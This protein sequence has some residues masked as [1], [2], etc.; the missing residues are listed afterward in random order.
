MALAVSNLN[1]VVFPKVAVEARL[2]KDLTDYIVSLASLKSIPLPPAIAAKAKITIQI[3]SL[4]V[5]NIL[6]SVEPILGFELKDS[7][8]RT[9]GYT[10]VDQAIA[11]LLPRIE[12]AWQKHWK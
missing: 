9:G 4:E 12:N 11:H 8:V 6:C 5:V 1:L 7:T 2:R 3:D 10:S